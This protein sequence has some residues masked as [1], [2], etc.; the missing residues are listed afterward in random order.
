M[1]KFHEVIKIIKAIT[2]RGRLYLQAS[3]LNLNL[4]FNAEELEAI[5]R[6][7]ALS[8]VSV[9]DYVRDAIK[10]YTEQKQRE[11]MHTRLINVEK[12]SPE[13]SAE[14]LALIDSMTEEDHEIMSVHKILP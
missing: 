1:L 3:A 8:Q 14:I 10:E 2:A 11:F 13:E 12:A 4:N 7:A 9:A 5:Q 6:V